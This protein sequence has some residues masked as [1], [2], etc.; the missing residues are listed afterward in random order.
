MLFTKWSDIQKDAIKLFCA[1]TLEP[2]RKHKLWAAVANTFTRSIKQLVESNRSQLNLDVTKLKC[3]YELNCLPFIK[4]SF[5]V[6]HTT[7]EMSFK[8]VRICQTHIHIHKQW[9]IKALINPEI[10]KKIVVLLPLETCGMCWQVWTS[11]PANVIRIR[12]LKWH[13]WQK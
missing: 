10:L 8:S 12:W 1:F 3:N 9:W 5:F 2:G 13:T 7:L 4:M 6:L 11:L